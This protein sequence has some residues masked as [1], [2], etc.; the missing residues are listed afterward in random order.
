MT[1]DPTQ[2]P[3]QTRAAARAL[4]ALLAAAALTACESN[5]TA[6]PDR[7]DASYAENEPQRQRDAVAI[8][9]RAF[10]EKDAEKAIALYREALSIYRDFY[11]A[12]NNLGTLLMQDRR[13][14]E[15]AEA[16]TAAAGLSP[17]DA[18]PVYNIGLLYDRS[19]YLQ[20][21]QTHYRRA[22]I[23]DENYLPALRG[24]IRADTILNEADE[25]TLESIR[26]ALRLEQDPRWREWLQLRKIRI[27]NIIDEHNDG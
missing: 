3:R 21:A 7:L 26:R 16:F 13:Y 14:L 19:G 10:E 2:S 12:W 23:R 6:R 1:H 20:D 5:N 15:A 24:L 17:D 8:A 4:A 9:A 18:R 25:D 11:P 22:L 27:Q